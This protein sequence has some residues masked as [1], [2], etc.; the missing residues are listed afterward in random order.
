MRGR[1]S[2][3]TEI[4]ERKLMRREKPRR[5]TTLKEREGGLYGGGATG[6]SMKGRTRARGTARAGQRTIKH[7]GWEN[8]P[9]GK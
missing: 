3:S 5:E 8:K 2:K 6:I 1:E 9:S 7:L 4:G